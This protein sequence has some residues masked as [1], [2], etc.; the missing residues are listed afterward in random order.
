M[1]QYILRSSRL[2]LLGALL[3]LGSN[4]PQMAQTPAPV[5]V[6]SAMFGAIEARHIGPATMSG[7]ITAIDVLDKKVENTPNSPYQRIIYVG[8]ALGGVWKSKDNGTTFKPIFDKITAD[9]K[10][11][12]SIGALTIDQS[13]PDEVVW[14]GTGECNVR[15]SVSVGS[16]VYKTTDG[17]ETW[18]PMGLEKTERIAKIAIHSTNANIVYVAAMGALWN[19]SEERGLYRTQDGGKTWEKVLYVDAETGCSD[20][21]IDPQNPNI[22]YAAFWTFRRKA[23]TFSSGG[24]GS[25]LFK[26][27]DGGKTWKRLTKG[28]PEGEQGRCIIAIAPSKPN[29]VFATVESKKTALYRSDDRGESWTMTSDAAGV[30]FRPYYFACMKV[31]PTDTNRIYKLGANLNISSDGGKTFNTFGYGGATH[32]DHH[33]I[34]IDPQNPMV[35]LLATDGGVYRSLDR[36]RSWSLFRNLPVSQFYHVNADMETP[37][38][39]FGGLQDNGSWMA[40][41][42]KLGGIPNSAW[43]NLGGGDGF[44]VLRDKAD[45]NYLYYTIYEGLAFRM[46][47]PTGETKPIRPLGKDGDPKYRFNWNSPLVQSAKNPKVLYT[48]AQYVFRST[49][50]GDTWERISEDLTTNDSTK[51]QQ[52]KSGGLT[53]DNTSAENHCTVFTIADSPLDEKLIWAGTDDGNLHITQDGGKTWKNVVSAVPNLPKN[54]WV[55]CVEP[56][57]FD[58]GTAYVTFDRHMDGDMQPHVYKTTD[59]GKTWKPLATSDLRGFAHVVREDVVNKNLLFV[60]TESGLFLS[61]DGGE[62]WAQFT[63]NMPNVAVRDVVI[64]PRE[65]DV[66]VATHGRGIV[67]VDDITPIRALTQQVLSS[68]LT[69]LPSRTTIVRA[70]DGGQEFSGSD[71]FV[72]A[73]VDN[74]TF[75][76]YY[77]KDRHMMGDLNVDILNDKGEL[78]ASI[79]GGKRKGINRVEWGMRLKAPRVAKSENAAFGAAFGP[80]VPD[81][82]YTV[83]IGKG[84]KTYTSTFTIQSDPRAPYSAAD[85]KKQ[86]ETMLGLYNLQ[87]KLAYIAASATSVRDSL[88][89]RATTLGANDP[90]KTT[91]T[92]TA[93]KFDSLYKKVV[94]E[95]STIFADTEERLRE[96]ITELY[97]SVNAYGG[98]PSKM[99]LERFAFLDKEVAKVGGE[100][101][102]LAKT[103]LEAANAAL[104]GKS[105]APVVPLT[106]E[107]FDKQKD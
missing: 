62:Q 75:I 77:M 86:Q 61:I 71:E 29:I 13:K 22:V 30:G 56:S 99:Q 65:H 92:Q 85:R 1:Q 21:A 54:S 40:P 93:A 73:T 15:N 39:V 84:D 82:K 26:S 9:L 105:L 52:E 14:V 60:G 50:K 53:P 36:G 35:L 102:T 8:T 44:Y 69:I 63:G 28:L 51:L 38:N 87:G 59:F 11:S 94:A 104:K 48:G 37:Y 107:A 103:A 66:I 91:L 57:R 42:Q 100:L 101:E 64:H 6:T 46:Y 31:D 32:P 58:K 45:K 67:I 70:N 25:G 83:R 12:Q 17:G 55:S 90:L 79:P 33:D 76:T 41:S 34:W 23:W 18:K 47:V 19:D 68:E 98:A 3:V 49:D 20:V 96:K 74:S 5:K 43:K 16:G 89:G 10:A 72:G 4:T 78:I 106:K 7:R 24:K 88:N 80:M 97:S 95:K 27:T 81:G 2:L